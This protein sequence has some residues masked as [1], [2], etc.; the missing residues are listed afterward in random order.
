MCGLQLLSMA[1][2]IPSLSSESSATGHYL[3]EIYC[4]NPG[5]KP[6][7]LKENTSLNFHPELWQTWSTSC[8]IRALNT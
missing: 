4:Q 2:I 7:W 5:V 6:N 8:R 3:A 1:N